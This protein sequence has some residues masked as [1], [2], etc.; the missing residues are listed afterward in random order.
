M[1][2]VTFD[3]SIVGRLFRLVLWWLCL[4]VSLWFVFTEG[5]LMYYIAGRE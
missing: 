4:A 1:V 3:L 2:W 5:E